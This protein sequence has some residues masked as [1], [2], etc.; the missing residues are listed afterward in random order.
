MIYRG[1]RKSLTS[2]GSAT[3]A[4]LAL[5]FGSLV[6]QPCRCVGCEASAASPSCCS[7][8]SERDCCRT[9][10]CCEASGAQLAAVEAVPC[11]DCTC[12]S[13]PEPTIALPVAQAPEDGDA[14]PAAL[15]GL[16]AAMVPAPSPGVVLTDASRTGVPPG[17]RLHAL[18]SVWLN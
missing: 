18:Y 9:R 2:N 16:P 15:V 5:T 13:A 17:M 10:A 12:S 8:A 6:P 4:A 11:S 3:L 7:E 14:A 1:S